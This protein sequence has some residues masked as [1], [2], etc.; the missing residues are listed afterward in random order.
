MTAARE[1]W[2]VY[3]LPLDAA[4]KGRLSGGEWWDG[5]TGWFRDRQ[6]PID[7]RRGSLRKRRGGLFGWT[8]QPFGSAG[9]GRVHRRADNRYQLTGGFFLP[10][11]IGLGPT[12]T[13]SYSLTPST[14][15]APFPEPT[16]TYRIPESRSDGS[17]YNVTC[18]PHLTWAGK[19]TSDQVWT[20]N[21]N[22]ESNS[23]DFFPRFLQA[24]SIT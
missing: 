17:I 23:T 10:I 24:R 15:I 16:P 1:D 12:P 18:Q 13:I 14:D 9:F 6:S 20:Y 19:G 21:F 7:H 5:S 11:D 4:K 22:P 3:R 8:L 2:S